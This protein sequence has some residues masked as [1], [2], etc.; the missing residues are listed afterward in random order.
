MP[1]VHHAFVS[2][3]AVQK[4]VDQVRASH[5][6]SAMDDYHAGWTDSSTYTLT[7]DVNG[8]HKQVIDY[9]G[10]IV[11]MPMSVHELE[12]YIDGAAG[13]AKWIE[14]NEALV[15]ALTAEH[16]DFAA[17]TKDNLR[18]YDSMLE[19][20]NKEVLSAFTAAHAPVF[21]TTHSLSRLYVSRVNTWTAT[22]RWKC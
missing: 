19:H 12:K 17:Q 1:G 10:P 15:P 3:E 11:G 8:I 7:L 21:R 9:I 5:V 16:W 20:G 13:A 18:L 14:G 4:L 22:R 6:L 2:H